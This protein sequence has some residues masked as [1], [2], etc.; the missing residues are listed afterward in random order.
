MPLLEESHIRF[1]PNSCTRA[2]S[3]V[4]VEHLTAT[5]CLSVASAASLVTCTRRRASDDAHEL[6]MG[7][8]GGSEQ[9]NNELAEGE[10]RGHGEEAEAH[11][12]TNSNDNSNK[13]T[14]VVD[15]VFA[16]EGHWGGS[17]LAG[18]YIGLLLDHS[19]LEDRLGRSSLKP[20]TGAYSISSECEA[21]VLRERNDKITISACQGTRLAKSL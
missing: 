5:W 7:T 20:A 4:M 1:K 9:S 15:T 18:K 10:E 19:I 12:Y 13:R 21:S 17:P 6:G 2:S 14:R 3:G 11:S 8:S 16:S